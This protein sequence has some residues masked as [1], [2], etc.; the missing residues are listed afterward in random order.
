MGRKICLVGTAPDSMGIGPYGNPEWEV[1]AC[2]PGTFQLIP[3]INVFFELH[4][5][6]PGAGNFPM[7]YV[8]FL[9]NFEGQ[10]I[11]SKSVEGLKQNVIL[12]VESL[13]EK[14][15]G[16]FFTSSLAWMLAMAIEEEPEHIALFGVDMAAA[17]EYE[18]QR[19]GCQFFALIAKAKGIQIGVPPESDLFCPAPLYGVCQTS[20][21]WIKQTA[22]R[23]D[24]LA[25][26]DLAG[27]NIDAA[28]KNEQFVKGCLSSLDTSRASWSGKLHSLETNYETVPEVPVFKELSELPPLVAVNSELKEDMVT[29]P[30]IETMERPIPKR[31]KKVTG[32]IS[33]PQAG[34][35][36]AISDYERQQIENERKKTMPKPHKKKKPK[37]KPYKK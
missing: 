31:E 16:Y 27:K 17:E 7:P 5:W 15:S 25:Q 11:T 26:L 23:N 18:A 8:E 32:D 20:H 12:P 4:R 34:E 1:W 36:H 10:V 33:D 37:K 2:S 35:L 14:Y 21:E 19:L 30:S 13:V 28:V 9:Q 29:F 6:L 24:L 3:N 22:R